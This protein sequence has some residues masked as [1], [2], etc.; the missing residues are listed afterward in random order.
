M[1]PFSK[2][3]Y[4][5]VGVTSEGRYRILGFTILGEVSMAIKSGT[6][7]EVKTG[8]FYCVIF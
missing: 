7:L 3:I 6:V 5:A 4:I 8:T 1:D 2:G